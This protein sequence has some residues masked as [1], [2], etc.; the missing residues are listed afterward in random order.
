MNKQE[1]IK[2]ELLQ[3]AKSFTEDIKTMCHW[4]T[5]TDKAY[6]LVVVDQATDE[7]GILL[8]GDTLLAEQGLF[9]LFKNMPQEVRHRLTMALSKV[10]LRELKEEE[11][12]KASA[13]GQTPS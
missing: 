2:S 11:A 10:M 13:L 3:A 6:I 5:T 9:K 7:A 12:V 1:P 8:A 4:E